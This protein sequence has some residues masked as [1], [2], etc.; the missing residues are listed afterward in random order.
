MSQSFFFLVNYVT[1]D[2][3][4]LSGVFVLTSINPESLKLKTGHISCDPKVNLKYLT[5][6]GFG[7]ATYRGQALLSNAHSTK[8]LGFTTSQRYGS[9]MGYF[10]MF[11][12]LVLQLVG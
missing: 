6:V 10:F 5:F 2:F 8:P 12:M 4:R 7:L 11:L 9:V 1:T 3:S